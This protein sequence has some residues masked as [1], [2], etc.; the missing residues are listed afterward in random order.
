[1]TEVATTVV[2][3]LIQYNNNVHSS[4]FKVLG[5]FLFLALFD[6]HI[7]QPHRSSVRPN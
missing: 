1:M 3:R 6:V 4:K 7:V 2:F 5:V